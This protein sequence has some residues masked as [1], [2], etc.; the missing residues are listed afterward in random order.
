MSFDDCD[1]VADAKSPLSTSATDTPRSASSRA[2]PAPAMPPPTTTTSYSASSSSQ[3]RPC[4]GQALRNRVAVS[5]ISLAP[6]APAARRQPSPYCPATTAVNFVGRSTL[7]ER[8]DRRENE[9]GRRIG[10]PRVAFRR[11]AR[12]HQ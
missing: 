5:L 1:V 9:I 10:D 2:T 4:T 8:S 3:G 12:E 7:H 11:D 6:R